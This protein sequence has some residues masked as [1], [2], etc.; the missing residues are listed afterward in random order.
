MLRVL[1]PLVCCLL[2]VKAGSVEEVFRSHQVVPDVIPEPPN[3][4]L[5]VTYSNNLVAKDGVELTPT[6]VKDQPVVEWDAQPGEFY[7]L[8]MTDPDAPSRAQPKFREFKHWILANIA[9]NDLASGEPIAE[10]IGSGPPQGTGLHRYVF[11]LYKQ[12]GKLEFD[13]ERESKRS[14]KDRPKFSAAKFAKKHELGNPIAG[15]FYQ[16]QYDDYVPKLH[17]QLSEN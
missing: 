1:L 4:L 14:R 8:I 10:Y 16:S 12:S 15:T 2:A 7:T 6:Q 5:K 17:K 13:E 3:Q 9:G 11:L